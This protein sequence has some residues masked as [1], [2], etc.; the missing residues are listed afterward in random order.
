MINLAKK[1]DNIIKVGE[2]EV[3]LNN[4]FRSCLFIWQE[5]DKTKNNPEYVL[6]VCVM[7]YEL[8]LGIELEDD[9]DI[10]EVQD[11][12]EQIFRYLDKH[13]RMSNV[14]S[15]I[16][17]P[18]LID[19]D[20]DENMIRDA[21]RLQGICLY[22]DDL[23]YPAFMS[24]FRNMQT[25]KAAYCRVLYLRSQYKRGKLTKEEKQEIER[26]WGWSMIKLINKKKQKELQ[27]HEDDFQ[28]EKNR[29]RA[30]Q[31]LPPL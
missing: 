23:D 1:S 10:D 22:S 30:E 9:F 16:N 2:R 18:N 27:Q 17:S 12:M 13:A 29:I 26:S 25:T 15:E 6:T 4:N 31:G 7:A 28:A 21:F 5:S 8:L 20:L 14:D 3:K 24:A 19:F 11:V